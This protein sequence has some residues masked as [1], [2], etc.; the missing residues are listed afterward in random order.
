MSGFL[1]K[2]NVILLVLL[3]NVDISEFQN[4]RNRDLFFVGG[5]VFIF[6][7]FGSNNLNTWHYKTAYK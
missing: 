1:T 7:A 6:R 2:K 4:V 3:E 5:F